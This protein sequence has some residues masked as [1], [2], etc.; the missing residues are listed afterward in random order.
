MK[1]V[2]QH[3]PRVR[4]ELEG[5]SSPSWSRQMPRAFNSVSL[6]S[7]GPELMLVKFGNATLLDKARQQF[8]QVEIVFEKTLAVRAAPTLEVAASKACLQMPMDD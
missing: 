1:Q 5:A 7:A 3:F 2:L 6:P 4:T 8:D